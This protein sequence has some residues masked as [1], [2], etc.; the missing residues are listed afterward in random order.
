MLTDR[1]EE[2]ENKH[3]LNSTKKIDRENKLREK[4]HWD[5]EIKQT[6]ELKNKLPK[7][8]DTIIILK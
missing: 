1:E 4:E 5:S 3:V 6:K 8:D 7:K 2:R